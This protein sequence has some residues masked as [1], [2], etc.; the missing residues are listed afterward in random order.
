MCLSKLSMVRISIP[1]STE[2]KRSLALEIE[3]S[4]LNH[5][6]WLPVP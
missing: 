5:T 2:G 6:Q 4:W 1:L 3:S